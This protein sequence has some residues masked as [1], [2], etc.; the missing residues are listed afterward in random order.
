MASQAD[1]TALR[2]LLETSLFKKVRVLNKKD[3]YKV[4]QSAHGWE[5]EPARFLKNIYGPSVLIC[6]TTENL[7]KLSGTSLRQ[8]ILDIFPLHRQE[9][10][11]NLKDAP[12]LVSRFNLLDHLPTD[13]PKSTRKI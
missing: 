13:H 8:D 12:T 4:M 3:L 10:W 2:L 5:E 9:K 11:C 7:E 6:L 1:H